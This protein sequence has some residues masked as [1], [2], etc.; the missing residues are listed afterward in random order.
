[1]LAALGFLAAAATSDQPIVVDGQLCHPR[2]LLVKYENQVILDS[3]ETKATVIRVIPQIQYTVVRSRENR[4][5]ATRRALRTLTGV[6]RVDLDRCSLPAYE[7]NDFHWPN[8]W[9]MKAIKANL[10]WDTTKGDSDIVVA[11]IDTG[12][13]VA[14]E[15]LAANIWQNTDEVAGN[16]IDDDANGYADDVNGYDFAYG[17]NNPNDVNGHGTA[18]S[19]IVAAMQDNTI[20]VTGV[21][22]NC[23]VMAIKAALDNGFFYD[24]ATI[25]AYIYSADN[26]ARVLSMSYFS[27]RVSQAERDAL[28]YCWTNG[29]LPVAAAGNSASIFP[30]Y[31]GGY[32]NVLSVAAV[33]A[34]LAKA[35][36]SNFGSWV[37]VSAPGTGLYTTTAAGAYT[38]SF[39]GTS[40]ACPHVAGVAALCF[41][42]NPSATNQE[43]RNAIEDTATLQSQ[44]P[45]GEFSNYGLVNAEAA[46][47]RMTGGGV[48]P[49]PPIVR[50]VTW[51]IQ[52]G[53]RTGSRQVARLY[54]RGF[55]APNTVEITTGGIPVVIPRRSRDWVDFDVSYATAG[56]DVRVNGA[57]ISF[58][59]FPGSG[60]TSYLLTE[61]STQG[62]TLEG[63]FFEALNPDSSF[64]LTTK[65]SDNSILVQATFRKVSP[66]SNM[67]LVLRRRYTGTTVGTETVQLYDWSS[68]SYPYG[69]FVTLG[70]GACPTDFTT[71]TFAVPNAQRFVDPEGTMYLLIKTSTDLPAGTKLEI[72]H[73]RLDV[74]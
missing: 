69:N 64:I 30:Y 11:V 65:R 9:H 32:E 66:V 63:G 26:G 71:S 27:D 20:G 31:P 70:S 18:C 72:D 47:L 37:D 41:S 74:L 36:F 21:A 55:G 35:S 68:A 51:Y 34:T 6:T 54:G 57:P 19:G 52:N 44:A 25:P 49:H 12:V 42:M 53:S 67:Q 3:L 46:V 73:V 60:T 50:Y 8:M 15:D 5:Q 7:P 16:G 1:M 58:I 17:D 22:P 2:N 28:E 38:T 39:G 48:Q 13:N 23:K 45:F 4:L 43:V 62:A 40:G 24:S 59:P 10:A 61:A 33:N 29:V 56:I 14:H